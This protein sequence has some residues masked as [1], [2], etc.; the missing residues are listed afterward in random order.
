METGKLS[1]SFLKKGLTLALIFSLLTLTF[2]FFHSA[3]PDT[4]RSIFYFN[5]ETIFLLLILVISSWLVEALRVKLIAGTLGEKVGFLNI[6]RINMVG[7]FTGNI[8][9][10]TSGS[11][12]A[13]VY[14]FHRLG[15]S[16]G[17]ATAIVTTRMVF[18][19]LFFMIGG[20]AALYLFRHRLLEELGIQH[21]SGIINAMLLLLLVLSFI[22]L[23]VCIWQPHYGRV[24]VKKV[25][26]LRLIRKILGPR[27][28]AIC[29]RFLCELQEFQSCLLTI[30]RHRF[31]PVVGVIFLT[32][33]Y[34]IINLS[35]APAVL[36]GFGVN[37]GKRIFRLLLLEFVI[38]FLVSFIPIPGGSGFTE[39]GLYSLF[40]IYLPKHLLAVSVV[41]WRF[42]SY[43]LTTL[44]GGL[45]FLRYLTHK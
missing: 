15:V 3:T 10:F 33:L 16:L 45:F 18:T 9:P 17:K 14:L 42:L 8:T 24:L 4:W 34:W 2:L 31:L 37:I 41:I 30:F 19:S 22:F 26:S 29:D 13:Q 40:S 20:P 43:Y 1:A 38:L 27:A 23:L 6:L 36:K 11:V 39:M 5:P 7:L 32:V 44:I 35:I 28:E 12:P 25:L 21:L